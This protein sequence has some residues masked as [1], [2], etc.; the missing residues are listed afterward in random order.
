[1]IRGSKAEPQALQLQ[2]GQDTGYVAYLVI[3]RFP[4][5]FSGQARGSLLELWGCRWPQQNFRVAEVT[6]AWEGE[7]QVLIGLLA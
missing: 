2:V 6:M 7:G 5:K 1:M 3:R 4:S